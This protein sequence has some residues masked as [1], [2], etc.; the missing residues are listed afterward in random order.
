M[1]VREAGEPAATSEPSLAPTRRE[2]LVVTSAAAAALIAGCAAGT[3]TDGGDAG[4]TPADAALPPDLAMLPIDPPDGV[5]ESGAFGLGV[6]SGDVTAGSALLWT[7]HDASAALT[8]SVWEMLGDTY[9]RRIATLDAAAIDGGFVHV[10]VPGLTAGA[11]YR[12]AFFEM[13]DGLRTA[14]SP[15][16]RFRAAPAD[17]T[18]EPLVIGAISCTKNGRAFDTLARAAE[19][20]DLA[21]FLLLGDTTYADG[22]KTLGEYRTRWVENLSTAAYRALRASTSVVATWDDHEV[23][24]NW[25]A[26]KIDPAKAATAKRALFENLPIRRAPAAPDRIWRSLRWGRTAELFVLDARGERRPSTKKTPQAEYLSRPQMDWLKAGLAASPSVFKLILNSVPIGSFPLAFQFGNDDR[27]EGYAAQRNEILEHV[28]K[29]KI[30]GVLWVSG[31]F[32]LAS[33][34]RVSRSGPGAAAIEV[35]A[36]PGAQTGNVLAAGL[37]AP[38]FDW[39]STTNNYTALHLDPIKSQ[40]RIVFHD[41]KDAIIA[42]RSYTL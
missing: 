6:A 11:R 29:Q 26:E 36:G 22:C 25:D 24:N 31:D 39:V 34:G 41:G 21:T 37:G 10:E 16:G 23:D 7:R 5:G 40:V 33:I 4:T 8:V 27:W 13:K 20:S 38:Q 17:S 42:D 12:Y 28:E 15:I 14:R 2:F 19:R 3:S 18:Q 1:K 30:G 35:L 32:H 9:A